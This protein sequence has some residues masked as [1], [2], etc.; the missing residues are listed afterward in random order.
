[1]NV[2]EF[3][4]HRLR[5]SGLKL[6]YGYPGDGVGT[7]GDR[8]GILLH[9][10][11][12]AGDQG[13]DT[14][15]D[16][17]RMGHLARLATLAVFL[18][19]TPA[20]A[21]GLTVSHPWLR[22]LSPSLPAAGYFTLSNNGDQPAVLT[23][24]TSPGCASIMLHRSMDMNGMARMEMVG[25]L[26]VPAHGAVIFQPGGY[27]LMCMSPT[28]ALVPGKA[29]EVSLHFKDGG[30]VTAAFQVRGATGGAS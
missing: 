3:V 28:A 6:V 10:V 16:R 27:H 22:V 17:G 12:G 20:F 15:A 30:T 21:A 29:V 13:E 11:A 4:W 25:D 19:T 2:S 23:G 24:A 1:M 18:G 7:D 26:P 5:E 8:T 9:P 14:G